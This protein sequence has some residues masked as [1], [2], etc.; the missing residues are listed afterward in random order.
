MR[1]QANEDRDIR[2]AIRDEVSIFVYQAKAMFL[3]MVL[4]LS[5]FVVDC[6]WT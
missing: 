2:D 6:R 5:F 4:K 3:Y 1:S